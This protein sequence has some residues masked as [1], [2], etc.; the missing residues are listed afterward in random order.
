[1]TTYQNFLRLQLSWPSKIQN[2]FARTGLQ[3]VY[4]HGS[5]GQQKPEDLFFAR[6]VDIFHQ[7][8]FSE[9][10]KEHS[11]L[12]TYKLV[13][14]K[15]GRE[16]YLDHIKNI[17]D[18]IAFTKFRLS[19]HN[20]MIEKGRHQNIPSNL[21]HCPHCPGTIEDKCHFLLNCKSYSTH[22]TFYERIEKDENLF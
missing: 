10:N 9:I 3:Y 7:N 5:N 17:Q 12:R 14:S 20:L 18:R 1:M 4:L 13:K 8:S 2:I 22:R 15:I 19:N 6:S 21:R 16:P 11:K